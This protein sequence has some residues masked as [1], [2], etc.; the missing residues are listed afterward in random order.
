MVKKMDK[1]L[2]TKAGFVLL[3]LIEKGGR[4][5]LINE[6]GKNKGTYS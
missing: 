5:F 4:D 6:V 1:F 2:Q 3:G